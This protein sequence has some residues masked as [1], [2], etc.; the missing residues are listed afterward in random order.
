MRGAMPPLLRLPMQP[1]TNPPFDAGE[2]HTAPSLQI[3]LAVGRGLVVKRLGPVTQQQKRVVCSCEY[4]NEHSEF[5]R[6][7]LD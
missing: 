4:G 6:I 5:R 2:M 3:V 7:L 1:E